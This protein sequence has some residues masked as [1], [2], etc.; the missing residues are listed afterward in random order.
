LGLNKVNYF[1]TR[2]YKNEVIKMVNDQEDQ[3]YDHFKIVCRE[4]GSEECEWAINVGYGLDGS[5]GMIYYEFT[6]DKCKNYYKEE[7][8]H[9]KLKIKNKL[10]R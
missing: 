10:G 2:I 7:V 8:W 3:C 1:L 4:C 6:C 9:G 5:P